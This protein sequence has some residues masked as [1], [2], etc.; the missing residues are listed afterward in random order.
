MPKQT[1]ILFKLI[2]LTIFLFFVFSSCKSTPDLQELNIKNNNINTIPIKT[3]IDSLV[4]L[5]IN[6]NKLQEYYHIKDRA[7]R[8]PLFLVLDSGIILSKNLNK[9]G[10]N[11]IQYFNE[12]AITDNHAFI[13]ISNIEIIKNNAS[14]KFFYPIE[15]ISG[16]INFLRINN[17]WDITTSELVEQ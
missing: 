11:I 5:T 1:I 7:K 4:L 3:T 12:D 8:V 14:L 10:E 13:K 9:F 16:I 17:K 15:G 2:H 6:L